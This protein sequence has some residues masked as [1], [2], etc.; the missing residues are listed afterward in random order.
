MRGRGARD[1][2]PQGLALSRTLY[3]VK[4]VRSLDTKSVVHF[5]LQNREGCSKM[6]QIFPIIRRDTAH[7]LLGTASNDRTGC[8]QRYDISSYV[9]TYAMVYDVMGQWVVRSISQDGLVIEEFRY[10]LACYGLGNRAGWSMC[11]RMEQTSAPPP[12]YPDL[13]K[14]T[15]IIHVHSIS[16]RRR[17]GVWTLSSSIQ[18]RTICFLSR[19]SSRGIGGYIDSWESFLFAAFASWAGKGEPPTA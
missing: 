13:S 14:D 10:V 19:K 8:R 9:H 7:Y 3:G 18:R 11:K 12:P 6:R 4:L 5:L 17:K 1:P 16:E 2:Y 15:H